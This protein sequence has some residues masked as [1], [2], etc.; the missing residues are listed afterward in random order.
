MSIQELHKP[1]DMLMGSLKFPELLFVEDQ[2]NE[3]I[4]K[5]DGLIQKTCGIL[6]KSGGKRVRPLLTLYSG[7]CFGPLNPLILRASVAAELI[8]MASLIHDDV[9]DKSATRRGKPTTNSVYGDHAA[10]LTGDYLFAEA[11]NIL[12]TEKLLKCMSFFIEAIQAM[13]AGEVNQAKEQ[14]SSAIGTDQY[15]KRI[16]QKTGILLAACCQSGA[17]LANAGTEEI[18]S[19]REFGLNIGYAYQ[20]TDDILDLNSSSDSLGKPVGADLQNGNMTLP[21]IYLKDN[22]IYGNW[23]QEIINSQRVTPQGLNSIYE[24]LMSSGC[25]NQAHLAAAQCVEKAKNSLNI[26]PP[27]PYRTALLNLS[28]LILQRTY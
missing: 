17:Q 14:F 20:I 4:N 9:I 22:P 25:L 26:I 16:A 8:H 5:A 18:L 27:S 12:S 21:L 23:L 7:M 28:D 19:L 13:C 15:F 24:A 6:L 11:F 1:S 3:I 2:L 10:I